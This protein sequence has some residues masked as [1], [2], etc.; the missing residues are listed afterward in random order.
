MVLVSKGTGKMKLGVKLWRVKIM[1][2][3]NETKN[4]Q[5]IEHNMKGDWLKLCIIKISR[6]SF[7]EIKSTHSKAENAKLYDV[8]MQRARSWI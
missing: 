1:N 7:P 5:N 3:K 4:K 6:V 8:G 2:N